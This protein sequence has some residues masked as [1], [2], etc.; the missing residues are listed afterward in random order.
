MKIVIS[1][2]L[3]SVNKPCSKRFSIYNVCLIKIRSKLSSNKLLIEI[4]TNF[5]ETDVKFISLKYNLN[6]I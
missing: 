4:T 6:L 3:V 2:Q 1:S 5:Y